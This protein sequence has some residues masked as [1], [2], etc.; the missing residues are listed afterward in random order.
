MR[1]ARYRLRRGHSGC[2]RGYGVIIA[3]EGIDGSGKTEQVKR[4]VNALSSV[5]TDGI[6]ASVREPTRGLIGGLIRD[7]TKNG[8]EEYLSQHILA[9]LF[10]ADRV[11]NLLS[12][13]VEYSSGKC[14]GVIECLERGAIVV[15]DRYKYSS[16]VYQTIPVTPHVMKGFKPPAREWIEKVNAYAPPAHVLVYID[17]DPRDVMDTIR[18]RRRREYTAFENIE[19]QEKA[20]QEY[21]NLIQELERNPEYLPGE[22]N[23]G[24]WAQFFNEPECMYPKGTG[25]PVIVTV[26]RK[27]IEETASEILGKV[28]EA[29]S[30]IGVVEEDI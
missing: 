12:A 4:L 9:L 17:A 14:K 6:V 29:L 16:L 8:T 27:S 2:R 28:L 11:Y 24:S 25:Y 20:R 19:F 15:F 21:L 3:M 30:R 26:E 7:I 18:R 5:I 10:A 13:P 23:P 22:F 1:Q